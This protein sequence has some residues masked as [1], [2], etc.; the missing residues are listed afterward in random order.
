MEVEPSATIL[1]APAIAGS[2]SPVP[3][4]R[5]GLGEVSRAR[6]ITLG[7]TVAPKVLAHEEPDARMPARFAEEARAVEGRRRAASESAKAKLAGAV[8]MSGKLAEDYP[9]DDAFAD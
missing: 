7:R 3:I 2:E 8:G 6:R 4:G 9:K 5:G 1:H